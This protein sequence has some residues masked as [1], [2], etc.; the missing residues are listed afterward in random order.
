MSHATETERRVRRLW[1]A[2]SSTAQRVPSEAGARPGE[3]SRLFSTILLLPFKT[4]ASFAIKLGAL[5]LEFSGDGGFLPNSDSCI[6]P[7]TFH[8]L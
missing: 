8:S 7:Q 4:Q 5:F 1:K 2:S 6:P 3:M